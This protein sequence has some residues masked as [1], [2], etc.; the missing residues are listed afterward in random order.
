MMQPMKSDLLTIKNIFGGATALFR[1]AFGSWLPKGPSAPRATVCDLGR[2]K[3]VL[4]ELSRRSDGVFIE[5]FE[6]IKNALQDTKPSLLLKPFFESGKF[7]RENIRVTLKGHGVILRFIRFPRMKP[8]DLR[9]AMQYEVEQ[10]IPFELKDC[11]MDYAIIDESVKTEEG[12]KM[13]VLLAVVKRQE[14]EPTVEV[15]RNL[16]CK[17]SVID[18]DILSAMSALECF[19]PEDAAGHSAILDIGTEI[20]TLGIMREGKPRFIRDIPY[21]TY[22]VHKRLRSKTSLSDEE[23]DTLFDRNAEE[24]PDVA[25]AISESL[26]GF[27]GDLKVS[28][29]YYRDQSRVAGHIGKLFVSGVG[30]LHPVVIG[31]LSE[32]LGIPVLGMDVLPKLKWADTVDGEQLKK[33]QSL[34]PVALGLGLRSE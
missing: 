11:V 31:T 33:H 10:Y 4:L 17:L 18:V 32:G 27:I 29:D 15:F 9:G 12:E 14:V 1:S 26:D 34:L 22:D 20:S 3:I 23:I 8:E 30:S 5:K 21:G 25:V 6:L 28:F 24:K 7:S 19:Y 13:E 2:S 16:E